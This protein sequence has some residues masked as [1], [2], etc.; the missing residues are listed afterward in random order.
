MEAIDLTEL[1]NPTA[2]DS[3]ARALWLGALGRYFMDVT[4][5]GGDKGEALA[6]FTGERVILRYLA[7]MAG[8]DAEAL[9]RV[10]LDDVQGAKIKRD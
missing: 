8:M 5:P 2:P 9:E 7:D 4:A 3:P 6:D 1:D 10:T